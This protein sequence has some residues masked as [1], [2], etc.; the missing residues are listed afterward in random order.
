ME[1]IQ[2]KHVAVGGLNIHVAEIGSGPDV[3]LL[4]GFPEIVYSWRYQMIALENAGFHAIAPDF[5]GYGMSDQPSEP[6]F[7]L[8]EEM[9]GLLNVFGIK[10]V[11][12]GQTVSSDRIHYQAPTFVIVGTKDYVQK[13]PGMDQYINSVMLKADVPKLI[14]KYL[15]C[16][17]PNRNHKQREQTT[18]TRYK[19]LSLLPAWDTN[20]TLPLINQ[21]NHR[22]LLQPILQNFV[23][24]NLWV[25]NFEKGV[26]MA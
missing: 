22:F 17:Q 5:R 3:L 12:I 16:S 13:L 25:P 9:V 14:V 21:S 4:H 24:P 7:D 19:T 20:R 1:K 23:V 10:K 2:H 11:W 15:K 6:D 8:V 26:Y 18:R